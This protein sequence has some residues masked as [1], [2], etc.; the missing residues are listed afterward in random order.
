VIIIEIW[1]NLSPLHWCFRRRIQ[2]EPGSCHTAGCAIATSG[3]CHSH[4]VSRLVFL[5][6]AGRIIWING[7]FIEPWSHWRG[8]EIAA[9]YH[10]Q[11]T[12]RHTLM[13]GTV[14]S[15]H[16]LQKGLLLLCSVGCLI[17]SIDI[18]SLVPVST[19]SQ[20]PERIQDVCGN[21]KHACRCSDFGVVFG[22]L[23]SN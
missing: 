15:L 22:K 8:D 9:L 7:W 10:F 21:Q 23:L 12:D 16:I 11:F 19:W 2:I 13:F 20:L 3:C 6:I 14:L 4:N 17:L 1:I 18:H 5:I